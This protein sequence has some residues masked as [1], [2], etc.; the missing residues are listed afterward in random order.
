MERWPIESEEETWEIVEKRIEMEL[1][2]T[3]CQMINNN[4]NI[5]LS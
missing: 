3:G 5:G 1:A 2:L 4:G